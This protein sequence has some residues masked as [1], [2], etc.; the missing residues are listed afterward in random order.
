MD[1]LR[2]L[3]TETGVDGVPRLVALWQKRTGD[4]GLSRAQLTSLAREALQTMIS[5]F[6]EELYKLGLFWKSSSLEYMH[7]S[8][9]D[10]TNSLQIQIKKTYKPTDI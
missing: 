9:A 2:E 5:E 1:A 3:S 10:H 7:T 8:S 4:V 6:S